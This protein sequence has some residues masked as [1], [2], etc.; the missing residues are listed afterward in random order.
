[1]HRGATMAL[2]IRVLLVDDHALFRQGLASLLSSQPDIEVVGEAVDGIE[3]QVKAQELRPDLI[4]MD[5]T[6]PGCDGLE[7]TQ[8][9]KQVLP[10]VRIVMLTVHDEDDRLFEAI[11][12]GAV[13]YLLK[14]T[15]AETLI[16]MLRGAMRGE[17]AISGAMAARM[18]GEFGRLA[19]Q[20]PF[21]PQQEEDAPVLTAREKEVLRLVA[22]G[23]M[24]KEIAA[25]LSISLST[26]KTHLRNILAKLQATSRHQAAAYAVRERLILP[27]E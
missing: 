17:A 7:A 3:A 4:L 16:P 25:E 2:P 26:V 5:L 15:A 23:A 6:M 18:L 19:R 24:D 10:D 14:S 12:S 22:T 20:T 9:I 27:P 8:R 21:R 11:K 13:G 1:G